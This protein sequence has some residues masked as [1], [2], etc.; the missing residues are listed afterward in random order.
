MLINT[1]RT[2]VDLKTNKVV[3]QFNAPFVTGEDTVAVAISP[4]LIT[5]FA[6]H[7]RLHSLL[8]RDGELIQ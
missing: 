4:L 7:G 5:S 1:I 8:W 3:K 2:I 6:L